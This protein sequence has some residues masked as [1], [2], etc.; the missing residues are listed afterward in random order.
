MVPEWLVLPLR[1][2]EKQGGK[3]NGVHAP[4]AYV[5]SEAEE[6]AILYFY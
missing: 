6:K 3:G 5:T 1:C 2:A 4:V